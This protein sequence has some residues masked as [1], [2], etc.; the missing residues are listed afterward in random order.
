[1][2]T[3]PEWNGPSDG[4]SNK[5]RSASASL[6]WYETWRTPTHWR[7]LLPWSSILEVCVGRCFRA[8]NIC[9]RRKGDT[10]LRWKR[11][12]FMQCNTNQCLVQAS[13]KHDRSQGRRE[14]G[15]GSHMWSIL[16][17]WNAADVFSHITRHVL[18][19]VWI[20]FRCIT[21]YNTPPR[22]LYGVIVKCVGWKISI[23]VLLS[24]TL[25]LYTHLNTKAF[26]ETLL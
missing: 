10:W 14:Q 6:S 21:L 23:D 3:E 16:L 5:E 17:K 13:Q 18:V 19:C 12:R 15:A 9:L 2:Y 20:W 7:Q 22:R 26:F 11:G 25:F 1:M 24:L 4:F 8:Q